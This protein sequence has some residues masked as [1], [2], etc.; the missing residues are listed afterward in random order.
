MALHAN[1]GKPPAGRSPCIYRFGSIHRLPGERRLRPTRTGTTLLG[2]AVLLLAPTGVAHATASIGVATTLTTAHWSFVKSMPSPRN[3]MAVAPGQDG[4]YAIGGD[5]VRIGCAVSCNVTNSVLFYSATANTWTPVASMNM[6]RDWLAAAEGL[7]GRIYALGGQSPDCSCVTNTVEAYDPATNT[8]SFVAS[9]P[10]PVMMGAATTGQNGDIYLLGGGPGLNTGTT[11]VLIYNP[12][13]NSWHFGPPMLES[14][15]ELGATTGSDG[16]I[17]AISGTTGQSQVFDPTTG[18]WSLLPAIPGNHA[19][20]Y[21]AAAAVPGGDIL[22]LG[23]C[24]HPQHQHPALKLVDIY[25]PQTN[26]WSVGPPMLRR[27]ATLGAAVI[28]DAVYAVGGDK[29]GNPPIV[30]YSTEVLRLG[31][32]V[33][34]KN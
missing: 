13:S 18:Q 28:G 17:Y 33:P 10:V 27:R 12:E 20:H 2:L 30:H 24:C 15:W 9:L 5:E 22:A 11:N 1:D 7:D 21:L 16:R 32:G 6:A 31:S 25:S 19:T 34:V 23:G 4:L 3:H 8:W 26:T 29:S 14:A